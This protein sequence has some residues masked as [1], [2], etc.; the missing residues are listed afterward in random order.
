MSRFTA[1]GG[2]GY[3]MVRVMVACRI[4]SLRVWLIAILVMAAGMLVPGVAA[5]HTGH[6]AHGGRA[7][8]WSAAMADGPTAAPAIGALEALQPPAAP[9]GAV[10]SPAAQPASAPCGGA[11]CCTAGHGCCAAIPAAALAEP[12]TPPPSR[13][14][15]VLAGLP[16]GIAAPALPEPPRP[17]R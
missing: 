12:A 13:P 1:R 10:A 5:A 16:P 8:A 3:A 11:A 9:S 4:P 15:A 6:D 14:G 17:F 2:V 7:D